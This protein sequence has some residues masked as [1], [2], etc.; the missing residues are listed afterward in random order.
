MYEWVE[1]VNI[2]FIVQLHIRRTTKS[3]NIL[4]E[5]GREKKIQ[6]SSIW[7]TKILFYTFRKT[8]Y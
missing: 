6:S 5:M 8:P 7:K 4:L 1:N 3:T 2:M